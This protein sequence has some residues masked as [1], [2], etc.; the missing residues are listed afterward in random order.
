MLF[1]EKQ[2]LI[3][4]G[5]LEELGAKICALNNTLQQPTGPWHPETKSTEDDVWGC[6]ACCH[7]LLEIGW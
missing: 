5:E 1:A 2:S 6:Q 4:V 7:P 3:S